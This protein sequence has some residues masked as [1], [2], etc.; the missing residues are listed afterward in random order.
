MKKTERLRLIKEM[1]YRVDYQLLSGTHERPTH[2]RIDDIGDVWPTTGTLKLNNTKGYIKGDRGMYKLA[3][4]LDVIMPEAVAKTKVSDRCM[5]L[6]N[7][8]KSLKEEIKHLTQCME[9]QQEQLNSI[10]FAGNV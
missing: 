3:E 1:C 7:E 10:F 9:D 6:E 4:V 5:I 8:V 2:I